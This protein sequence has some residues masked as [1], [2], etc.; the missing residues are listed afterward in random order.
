MTL[1]DLGADVVKVERPGAGDDTRV[2]GPAVRR[3]RPVDLLPV[4]QPQQAGW[5]STWA[6]R[7]GRE[8]RSRLAAAADVLV[9][10]F[11]P[12]TMERFGLGY[13]QL[14]NPGLVYC[15]RHRLRQRR[16]RDLPG[17]DFLVQ[18]VG[19]LMCIT[20]EPGGAPTKVG[21]ALV[22]VLAGLHADAG[23][24]AALCARERTGRGQR[25]EVD[26]LSSLL[27]AL[28]NQASAYLNAGVVPQPDGQPAPEHRAVRDAA[29]RR[30]RRSRSRWAT[31][32]S[33]S[34]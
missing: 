25:V 2:V 12:G 30:R 11:R 32:A 7:T 23:I 3:R 21:V 20:G 19:G 5:R 15:Q 8:R 29:G 26:L 13:E 4:G 9:E 28:V 24:L 10:N 27:A 16:R 22:D 1:G 34:A 33:S 6:P 14:A 18:A 31:T 17:Y